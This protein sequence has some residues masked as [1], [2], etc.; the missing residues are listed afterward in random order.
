MFD[1]VKMIEKKLETRRYISTLFPQLLDN[2][3]ITTE[4]A[5]STPKY[6]Y[7]KNARGLSLYSLSLNKGFPDALDTPKIYTLTWQAD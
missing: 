3:E 2:W 5:T 6:I 7:R 1:S 4:Y